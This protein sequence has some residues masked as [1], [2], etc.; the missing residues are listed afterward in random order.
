LSA[1]AGGDNEGQA[2]AYQVGI[3]LPVLAPI[4]AHRN[5]RSIAS[6]DRH[7]RHISSAGNV[8]HQD[9]I[10]PWVPVDCEANPSALQAWDPAKH[11]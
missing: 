6:S 3:G 7:C 10:E 9:Q 11:F 2:L 4:A 8:G 1:V 5:P